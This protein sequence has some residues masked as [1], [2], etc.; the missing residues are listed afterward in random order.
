M[1]WH[2]TLIEYTGSETGKS[3]SIAS[4][5]PQQ[6]G[7]SL[8]NFSNKEERKNIF[9]LKARSLTEKS[10][11]ITVFYPLNELLSLQLEEFVKEKSQSD[12]LFQFT[13]KFLVSH[14]YRLSW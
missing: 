14:N 8:R 9:S 7:G 10:S 12:R 6:I 4:N 2:I 11:S 13:M 1:L 5:A 3:F